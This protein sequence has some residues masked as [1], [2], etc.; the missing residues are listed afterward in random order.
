V[1]KDQEEVVEAAGGERGGGG[2]GGG[3]LKVSPLEKMWLLSAIVQ[4]EALGSQL[5]YK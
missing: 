5:L 1:E 3:A 2:G 4:R